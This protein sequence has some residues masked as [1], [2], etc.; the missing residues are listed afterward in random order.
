M[1]NINEQ[2][3]EELKKIYKE[4]KDTID[5][6]ILEFQ[7]IWNEGTEEEIFTEFAFCIFTPQSKARSCSKAID[8]LKEKDLL[9]RGS[10]VQIRDEINL[11]RFRN[12]KSEYLVEA[13]EK[14]SSNGKINIKE[15]LEKIENIVERRN[16]LAENMK[17]IGYKEA[18]HFLR[19]VGFTEDLAILDRHILKNLKIL[20]VIEEIPKTITPKAYFE[21]ESKMHAFAKQWGIGMGAL[22]FVLWYKEAGEV[23]K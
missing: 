18:G 17:G 22:D 11:V 5:K 7:K 6:R 16:W 21:I 12:K 8:I 10:A 13:R 19:N 20:N 2:H 23:F 14:F 4:I 15:Q 3:F 1:E 9:F